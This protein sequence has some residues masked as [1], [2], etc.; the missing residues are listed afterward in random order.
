MFIPLFLDFDGV[1]HPEHCPEDLH[2]CRLPLFE[3]ALNELSLLHVVVSSTW[4][5]RGVEILRAGLQPQLRE[6]VLG[7]TPQYSDL[8]EIPPELHYF[9]R[10]A[11][12]VAWLRRNACFGRPW[13]ALDDR[14]WLFRPFH[15]NLILVD[16]KKGLQAP[17]VQT[18]RDRYAQ[19][20]S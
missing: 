12:C 7:V 15:K 3:Q 14:P 13:L 18:M 1:L 4:R 10:E 6:R 11:E 19:A 2:L 5:E 20:L 16:G 17:D 8:G 9:G